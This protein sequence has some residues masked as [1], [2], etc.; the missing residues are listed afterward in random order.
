MLL[1]SR[2]SN[3]ASLQALEGETFPSNATTADDARFDMKPTGLWKNWVRTFFDVKVFNPLPE[4]LVRCIQVSRIAKF[5]QCVI[6]VE[7]ST[8][9]PLIF[10]C[11]GGAGPAATKALKEGT[12]KMLQG[13]VRLRYILFWTEIC[14]AP[15]KLFSLL[16]D[17]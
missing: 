5:E 4:E 2:N 15:S 1:W 13:T 16:N 8:F 11:T 14:F 6:N 17:S 3:Q 10:A 9:N 7:R 12:A